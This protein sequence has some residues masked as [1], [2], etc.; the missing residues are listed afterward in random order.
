LLL[1]VLPDNDTAGVNKANLILHTARYFQLPTLLL[2][3]LEI[4]PLLG[5]GEDIEQMPNLDADRLM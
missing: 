3:P 2:D 1:V 5:D 4:E